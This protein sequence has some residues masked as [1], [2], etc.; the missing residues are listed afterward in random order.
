[1]AAPTFNYEASQG[2]GGLEVAPRLFQTAL[3]D[4][5]EQRS[6]AGLVASDQTYKF[7]AKDRDTVDIDAMTAF[8][9][10]LGP[11]VRP[12]YWT[13]PGD[14]APTLWVQDGAYRTP[15]EKATSKDLQVTFKKWNG[16]EE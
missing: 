3:G 5:Y 10:G 8:L 16:A 11:G 7:L 15:N 12:F 4:A 1:M 2:S 6:T 14:G 9:D 13:K